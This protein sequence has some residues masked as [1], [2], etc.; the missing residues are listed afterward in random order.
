[1]ETRELTLLEELDD[2]LEVIVENNNLDMHISKETVER[3]ISKLKR[4]LK[5]NKEC[6]LSNH[7][8]EAKCAVL[9]HDNHIQEQI[10]LQLI[11]EK[12]KHLVDK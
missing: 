2:L 12:Y 6:I 11:Y 3:F 9:E 7:Q 5:F 4:E 10:I 1:M 8:C